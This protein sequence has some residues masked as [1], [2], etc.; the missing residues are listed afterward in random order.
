MAGF[1]WMSLIKKKEKK[2][3]HDTFCYVSDEGWVQIIVH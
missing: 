3:I 1:D 2:R